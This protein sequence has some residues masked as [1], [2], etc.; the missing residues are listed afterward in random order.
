M[1]FIV[2]G[3]LLIVLLFGFTTFPVFGADSTKVLLGSWS[4][5]AMAPDGGPPS[6][7]IQVTFV[8]GENGELKGKLLV[9]AAGGLQYSGEVSNVKMNKKIVSATVTFKLGENPLEAVVSGPLKG[10]II[11]GNFSVT[12]SKGEK[13]GEGTFAITKDVSVAKK[14]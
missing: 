2:P 9:K 10:K 7:D 8:K 5:K 13:I 1:K 3:L 14:K 12:S 6:G 11:E 4:G